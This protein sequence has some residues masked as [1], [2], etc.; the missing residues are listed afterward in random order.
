MFQRC[1][2]DNLTSAIHASVCACVSLQED[3]CLLNF[4]LYFLHFLSFLTDIFGPRNSS[5]SVVTRLRAGPFRVQNSVTV[6]NF[7]VLQT[8]S[9]SAGPHPASDSMGIGVHI[10]SSAAGAW[11]WP[12]PS[13]GR[14]GY[15]WSYNSAPPPPIRFNGVDMENFNFYAV[16]WRRKTSSSRNTGTT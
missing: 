1:Y 14:R 8:A 6:T 2:A 5:V 12:L 16:T 9:T 3:L 7:S 13:T 15:K 4:V 11:C 10:H